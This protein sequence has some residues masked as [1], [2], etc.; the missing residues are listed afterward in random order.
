M[1]VHSLKSL[2]S[3]KRDVCLDT[4]LK[5]SRL[6]IDGCN[7]V[8]HLYFSSGLDQ[9]RGGEYAAFEDL[10]EQ[11]I[12]A[13][14][15]CGISPYVVLDGCSDASDRKLDTV[16]A[17]AEQRIQ[18]AHRAAEEDLQMG[19]MP[20]MGRAVFKQTLRRLDVPMGRSYTEADQEI[21]ALAQE[22]KCPVLSDDTDFYVFELSG[23]MLPVSHFR[24]QEVQQNGPHR[25]IPCK[26]YY[27]SSFC[28]FFG[29]QPQLLPCFAVLAGNDFV[30]LRRQ[31]FDWTQYVP[32]TNGRQSLDELEGI[33]RWIRKLENVS[34]PQDVFVEALKK[35]KGN[36]S[37]KKKEELLNELQL[38]VEEY[39]VPRSSLSGFFSEHKAPPLPQEMEGKVPD[40]MRLPVTDAR[41]SSD[42]LEVLTMHRI[43]L[44]V[45]VDHKDKLS[46]KLVSR[47]LR[48]VLYALLLGGDN[49]SVKVEERDRDGLQL[50]HTKVKPASTV[51]PGLNVWALHQTDEAQR[52][53]VLLD[54]LGLNKERLSEL[55]SHLRH[56][57]L[58]LAVTCYWL[59]KATPPPPLSLL[60]ALLIGWCKGDTLRHKAAQDPDLD[61]AL[62]LDWCH[63]LNEWQACL[64][65]S[66]HLNQLLGKPLPEPTISG[67]YN[68]KLVYLLLHKLS[69][70]KLKHFVKYDAS[71]VSDY[72]AL[73]AV[74]RRFCRPAKPSAAVVGQKTAPQQQQRPKA[75]NLSASAVLLFLAVPDD[76]ETEIQSQLKTEQEIRLEELV[77]LKTRHKTKGRV[78]RCSDVVLLRKQDRRGGVGPT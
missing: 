46:A 21:A 14:R 49:G 71:S 72:R 27:S 75:V 26:R 60:K 44:G 6:V 67:L 50:K 74:T 11:F 19:I 76:A 61:R 51:P 39:N 2:V 3:R 23:G 34:E 48:R 43:S 32:Q 56:L 8:Y 28:S 35:L 59:Q 41:F 24:W 63:W 12:C 57:S 4:E 53:Q 36:M 17:R 38:A 33:L 65:D 55:P 30:N 31:D 18:K 45:P 5:Y 7:L 22:W 10:I 42:F 40:W 25:S 1:G 52:L 13:L 78:H 54:A 9:N 15:D 20:Q 68:G 16:T 69:C 37:N 29:I 77:P 64:K 47:P 73:L 70:G 58:P 66:S 62:D